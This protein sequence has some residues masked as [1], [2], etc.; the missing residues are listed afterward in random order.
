M[1]CESGPTCSQ[2]YLPCLRKGWREGGGEEKEKWHRSKK[3]NKS[4]RQF[5]LGRDSGQR[6]LEKE[7]VGND[8][9]E[10]ICKKYRVE[11]R[12]A[13]RYRSEE[14][15]RLNE[16]RGKRSERGRSRLFSGRGARITSSLWSHPGP[17]LSHPPL[18]AYL[19]LPQAL[20]C[21]KINERCRW[22]GE[23]EARA[24]KPTCL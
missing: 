21:W 7:G 23:E 8:L 2:K 22:G 5:S 19:A 18:I 10:G 6:K 11:S 4:G 20:C 13:E 15:R 16:N 3:K 17:L 12:S 1:P 9:S 14:K 24:A